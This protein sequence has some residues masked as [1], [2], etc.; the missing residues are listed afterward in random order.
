VPKTATEA[1]LKKAY[2]KMALLFHPDK[3]KAPGATEAFKTI[4]KAFAILNDTSKRRQYDQLGP[5]SFDSSNT[6]SEMRRHDH[7]RNRHSHR[8]S[9]GYNAQYYWNDE[10]F[11]ADE[12][13]NL[14]FGVNP[15]NRARHATYVYTTDNRNSNVCVDF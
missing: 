12:L 14:F 6:S 8:G 5:E 2:R 4:G 13:F 1:D 7:T 15:Q 3:N 11:S 9:N 10:D